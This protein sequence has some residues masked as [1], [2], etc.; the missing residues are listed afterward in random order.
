MKQ[1]RIEY[2]LFASLRL[3]WQQKQD[4]EYKAVD[5]FYSYKKHASFVSKMCG[6]D[7]TSVNML[8][9]LWIFSIIIAFSTVKGDEE[10]EFK[11]KGEN[12]LELN[13][14]ETDLKAAKRDTELILLF[15]TIQSSGIILWATGKTGDTMLIELVRGKVR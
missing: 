3:V 11:F 9:T 10:L 4:A 5:G 1:A 2:M 6:I 8:L 14:T 12:L 7:R 13:F 15:K